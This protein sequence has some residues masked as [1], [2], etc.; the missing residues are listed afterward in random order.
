MKIKVCADMYSTPW[1]RTVTVEVR[2]F[3]DGDDR[4]ISKQTI[5]E[6][7]LGIGNEDEIQFFRN[8]AN[9]IAMTVSASFSFV[10]VE[11]K[12]GLLTSKDDELKSDCRSVNWECLTQYLYHKD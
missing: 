9:E 4:P 12:L 3:F 11:H 6:K 5:F 2:K 10:G 1:S 7:A 8:R